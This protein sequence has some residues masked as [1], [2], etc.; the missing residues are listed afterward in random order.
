MDIPH[1]R[2][3]ARFLSWGG[4]HHHIGLN[5]WNSAGAAPRD[6]DVTGLEA[7]TFAIREESESQRLSTTLGATPD[8]T[9]FQA[10]E[11]FGISV[12][13]RKL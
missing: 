3:G 8:A 12:T 13:F 7:M 9:E 11:P 4:H 10:R 2:P 1:R 6:P 5:A